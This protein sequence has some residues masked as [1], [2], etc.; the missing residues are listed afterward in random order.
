MTGQRTRGQDAKGAA[1]KTVANPD[2][3]TTGF[4]GSKNIDIQ[5]FVHDI[6]VATSSSTTDY[7]APWSLNGKMERLGLEPMPPLRQALSLY[8]TERDRAV[9]GTPAAL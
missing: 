4:K 5:E 3:L 1:A 7:A 2:D 6:H 8:F 9:S